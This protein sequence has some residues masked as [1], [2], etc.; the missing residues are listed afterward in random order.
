MSSTFKPLVLVVGGTGNIGSTVLQS[1][2]K[3]NIYRLATL[4]RSASLSK[5]L[6]TSL[7]ALG[8]EIRASDWQ[9]DRPEK[10]DQLFSGSDIVISTVKSEALL[11]QKILV[12]AA[13][14]ANV[15]R[16]I[17]S[18]FGIAC[19]PGVVDVHD[20]KSEIRKYIED[21]GV[22]HTYID[23]GFWYQITVPYREAV[24]G[25]IPEL[26]R[27]FYGDGE[28][29]TAMVNK[30]RIGLFVAQIIADPRTLNQYVF[31]YDD[32]RTLNEI[33][34]VAS[35]IAGEDFHKIKVVVSEEEVHK[36]ANN[37]DAEHGQN[38]W[39]QLAYSL[40]FRGD[41]TIETAKSQGAL[42]GREL[43]PE[44]KFQSLEEYA[45]EFYAA[46]E[47]PATSAS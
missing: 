18:D 38:L 47:L 40:Y 19:V 45:Q 11:D 17:P 44:L 28:K 42:D 7:S 2:A 43:Y 13:K 6:V 31:I 34:E 1:L 12:D 20:E 3:T 32:A 24:K 16:F 41:N 30:E 9:T 22:P 8:I 5:P 29:K 37:N 10:L 33:Y 39:Y 23:V 21:S 46:T 25:Q 35:R 27:Q 26:V 4:V 14:R 36:R 15:K